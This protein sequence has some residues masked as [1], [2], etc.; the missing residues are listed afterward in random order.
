MKLLKIIGILAVAYVG[1]V[2]AFETWLGFAQPTSGDTLVITTVDDDG[3]AH[4][5]V[6]SALDSDGQ[7]YVSANHWPRAW[8]K[9]IL[10]RPHVQVA[11]DGDVGTFLA[12]PID[13]AE[14]ARVAADHPHSL[15]F[16]ILTGFPP[17]RFV[18]LDPV[19]PDMG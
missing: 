5:R 12:V 11:R 7:L 17:R 8:F 3:A 6:I 9:H 18:R 2:V 13:G 10:Q 19:E 4:D 1:L 15:V 14:R 16:R